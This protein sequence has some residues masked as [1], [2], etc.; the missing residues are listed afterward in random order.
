MAKVASDC[1]ICTILCPNFIFVKTPGLSYAVPLCPDFCRS[2][3]KTEAG[4][5]LL[6]QFRDRQRCNN[7]ST[8]AAV[9]D[10]MLYLTFCGLF[11]VE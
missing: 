2:A 7:V 11:G 5:S 1:I 8:V 6:Q 3:P 10:V 4:T 9:L